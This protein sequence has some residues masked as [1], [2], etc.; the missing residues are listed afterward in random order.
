MNPS[1]EEELEEEEVI[2]GIGLEEE[3]EPEHEW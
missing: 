3:S 2:D 1:G